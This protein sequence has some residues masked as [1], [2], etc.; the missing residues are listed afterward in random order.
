MPQINKI[1]LVNDFVHNLTARI[2]TIAQGFQPVVRVPPVV[3]KG[4]PGGT[5]VTFI[6]HKVY[7]LGFF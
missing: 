7:L 3:R 2:I 5:P 4:L 6:F 1:A